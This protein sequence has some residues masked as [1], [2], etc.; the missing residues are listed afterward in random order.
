M[1]SEQDDVRRLNRELQRTYRERH[2]EDIRKAQRVAT[3][4]MGLRTHGVKIIATAI[5]EF[6]TKDEM[7]E[8]ISQLRPTLK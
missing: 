5:A 7:K 8:L 3:A 6:V 4:L 2:R 1:A